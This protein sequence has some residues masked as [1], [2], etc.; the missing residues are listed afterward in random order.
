MND[1]RKGEIAYQLLLM[2]LLD[3]GLFFNDEFKQR[4][5]EASKRLS[6]PESEMRNFA[7]MLGTDLS[8][9]GEQQTR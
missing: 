7:V 2:E 6:I 3:K 9:A 1:K 4:L 5:D 8:R